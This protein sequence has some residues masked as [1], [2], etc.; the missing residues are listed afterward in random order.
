MNTNLKKDQKNG[1]AK[2][3]IPNVQTPIT[4]PQNDKA[5]DTVKP[6]L[7]ERIQKVEELRSLTWK[8]QN[9]LNTLHN[10]RG[11]TFASDENCK[12]VLMD[13]QNNKFETNNTNL[14]TM[15]TSYFIAVLGDKV[16]ALDD[17]ILNFKL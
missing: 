8:R 9:T 15:L 17:E 3:P 13:S 14:I 7:D 5:A 1:I 6:S 12:L 16:S 11:F 4:K 2:L 10:L